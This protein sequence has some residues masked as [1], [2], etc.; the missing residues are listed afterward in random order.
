MYSPFQCGSSLH[1]VRRLEGIPGCLA[2][3]SKCG[4]RKVDMSWWSSRQVCVA[5]SRKDQGSGYCMLQSGTDAK[6]Y[7]A[8]STGCWGAFQL[9]VITSRR[10]GIVPV[11]LGHPT[12]WIRLCVPAVRYPGSLWPGLLPAE[13]LLLISVVLSVLVVV[14]WVGESSQNRTLSVGSHRHIA[15]SLDCCLYQRVLAR[16][17]FHLESALRWLL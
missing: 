2:E 7:P 11:C 5:K 13:Q 17:N 9:S 3:Q 8:E 4:S 14:V 6:G 16:G 1:H 10:L 15:R 12:F